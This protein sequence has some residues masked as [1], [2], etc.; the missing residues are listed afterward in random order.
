[1]TKASA[2]RALTRREREKV[3]HRRE[4]LEA[5]ERVFAQKGFDGATVEDIARAA[6]FSVGALYNFFPSKEVLWAEVI[7]KIGRDF[8]DAFRKGTQAADGPLEAIRALIQLKL[9]HAEAHG[10]F[11]RVFVEEQPGSRLSPAAALPRSCREMYDS[12]VAETTALFRAA[13]VEGLLRKADPTYTAL[14]LEGVT[15]TF[16]TYWMRRGIAL[17]VSEQARLVERHFLAAL[18]IRK[19]EKTRNENHTTG[20]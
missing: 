7:T 12:Y 5:A 18:E 6:E 20:K 19:G 9:R 2:G 14:S 16:K 8:R 1:M 15:N 4:I 3:S 10:A 13:M 11:L 17:P